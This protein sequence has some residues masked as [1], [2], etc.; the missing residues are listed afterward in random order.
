MFALKIF[1]FVSSYLDRPFVQ[2][3]KGSLRNLAAG[4]GLHPPS[5]VRVDHEKL[6]RTAYHK[7]MADI[8]GFFIMKKFLNITLFLLHK[9]PNIFNVLTMAS[10]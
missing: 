10:S 1:P 5:L 7:T 4:G 2:E 3:K 6:R 8:L 9:R